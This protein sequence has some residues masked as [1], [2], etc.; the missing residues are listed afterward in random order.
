MRLFI[1]LFSGLG[2]ASVAFDEDP[3]WKTVKIDN[4]PELVQHNRGLIVMDIANHEEVCRMIEQFIHLDGLCQVFIWASVPCHQFSWARQNSDNPRRVGQTAED[5]D[6][7]LFDATCQII[8]HFKAM[9]DER[10]VSFMWA[11]ENVHGAKP[12]FNEELMLHPRQEIGSVVLWGDFP[13]IPIME[14]DTWKH[15]KLE[16]K[17]SRSLRPNY[18]ALTPRPIS[19]GL[20]DAIMRQTTIFQF[21]GE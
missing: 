3:R 8:E 2:G 10:G 15:R 13:L 20:L 16:A 14:R 17:G 7:T 4:N 18:R 21:S 11:I 9:F 5:F 19:E 6:L 1:D 12:I